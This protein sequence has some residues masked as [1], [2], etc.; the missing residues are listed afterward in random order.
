MFVAF[1]LA[2][3]YVNANWVP[4]VYTSEV[5]AKILVRKGVATQA[6]YVELLTYAVLAFCGL[7]VGTPLFTFFA[8]ATAKRKQAA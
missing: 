4:N 2:C 1:V 5:G 8:R 7:V 3:W 6:Y